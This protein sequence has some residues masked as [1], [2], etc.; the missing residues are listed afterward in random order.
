[1][2]EDRWNY[3]TRVHEVGKS[4]ATVLLSLATLA[5]SVAAEEPVLNVYNWADYIHPDIPGMFEAEYGIKINYD[6]Y[7]TSEMVDVKL[8][9]G[10][11]G[12]DIVIHAASFAYR[13]GPIGAFE[14]IQFDKLKNWHH[15]D[16][17]ILK[18]IRDGYPGE[19]SAVPYMWGTSGFSY[20]IDMVHERMPDA[21]LD[22]AALVFDPAIIS[23]FAD[24]GVTLLDDPTTV[25]PMAM[26]YLGHPANSI[27]KQHLAEVEQLLKNIRPYIKYFS[28][29]KM[30]M[31]MPNKETCISMSWSGDY[32]VAANRAR[33]AGIEINLGYSIP[34]EGATVW[35][36]AAY[37]PADA[38]H[39]GNAHLFLDFLLRP[40]IIAM[41]SNYT[42]YANAN[43]SA[44]PLV[45][46]HLSSNP[47]IYPDADTFARLQTV[48]VLGPKLERRRSRTWTRVKSGL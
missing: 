23:R 13:L 35:F 18:H 7:D 38:P 12:Y 26:I 1:M 40:E 27:E 41:A 3:R 32:S 31:D 39:P 28:S 46:A 48:A 30:L 43:G 21:P 44:T 2:R 10:R 14:D 19:F 5:V 25:I 11:T 17:V 9:T 20:N 42:G 33:E 24:C 47:A 6:I 16:P 15:I 36:D 37:I 34:K 45:E 4:L 8:M 29:T 22:S